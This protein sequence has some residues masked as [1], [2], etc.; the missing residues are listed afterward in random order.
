[1]IPTPLL[2][3]E[4]QAED[5]GLWFE[6]QTAGEAY[7][8][9]ALRR[10]HAAVEKEMIS[11]ANPLAQVPALDPPDLGRGAGGGLTEEERE[12]IHQAIEMLGDYE[13]IQREWGN[14]SV[15]EGASATRYVLQK[16][17]R[18]L[19]RPPR[20]EA[21]ERSEGAGPRGAPMGHDDEQS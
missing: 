16:L 21:G 17:F 11:K 3:V 8:Q 5:E 10:L 6:A 15:A 4:E 2:I 19:P 13:V 9:E 20:V 12:H 18:F 14:D 1:M 7:L